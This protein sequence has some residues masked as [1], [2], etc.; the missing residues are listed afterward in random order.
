MSPAIRFLCHGVLLGGV[1]FFGFPSTAESALASAAPNVVILLADDL[2]WAD[3]GYH[4]GEIKT[5]AIDRLAREGVRGRAILL[6][7]HLL[8]HPCRAPHWA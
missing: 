2:G 4:G 3:V 5:P 1:I 8:P 6:G 7:A